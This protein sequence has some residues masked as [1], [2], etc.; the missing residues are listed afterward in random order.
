MS[1]LPNLPER[2]QTKEADFG[3]VFRRWWE[4]SRLRGEIELKDS[5]GKDYLPFSALSDDQIAVATLATGRKGVLVRRS[6]GTTG[7]ADYS[8]LVDSPYW[9]VIKYK[10]AFYVISVNTFLLEK[11]RS[12]R[13]SLIEERAREIATISVKL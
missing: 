9:V 3:V 8:G 4:K 11:S 1:P 5:L 6:L 12:R 2:H 10:K 13:R 7:G